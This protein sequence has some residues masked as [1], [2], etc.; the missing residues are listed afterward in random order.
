MRKAS[1]PAHGYGIFQFVHHFDST[2]YRCKAMEML[3]KSIRTG[4]LL[5]NLVVLLVAGGA[6]TAI[7][8]PFVLPA[9]FTLVVTTLALWYILAVSLKRF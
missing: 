4:T 6:V 5:V 1:N 3:P 9:A 2:R 7:G 8:L